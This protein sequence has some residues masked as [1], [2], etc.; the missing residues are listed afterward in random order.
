MS[1]YLIHYGVPGMKWGV[2][3][4]DYRSTSIRGAIARRQNAKVNEGFRKWKEGAQ[5]RDNAIVLG[6]E[7]N[8]LKIQRMSDPKN[9]EL[10]AQYKA[11]NKEYKKALRKNTLYRKGTVRQDVG[12][13]MARKQLSNAKQIKKQLDM[14]P[15]NKQL[16]KQYNKAMN[17]HDVSLAKARRAQSVGANRSRYKA[18]LKRTATVTVK[19]ATTAAVVSA[20]AYAINKYT[21]SDITTADLSS[22][23]NTIKNISKLFGMMY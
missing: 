22:H 15:S 20:G 17:A 11:A 12:R 1:N 9:K 5:N 23:M 13:D 21:N 7:A 10:K 2:R 8:T 19:A 18:N 16:Q 14:D 4:S 3:K 6:K